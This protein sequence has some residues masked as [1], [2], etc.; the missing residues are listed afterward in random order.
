[1]LYVFG[2]ISMSITTWLYTIVAYDKSFENKPVLSYCLANLGGFIS[3]SSWMFLIRQLKDDK[4]ILII[5]IVWDVGI[6][7]MVILFPIFLFNVKLDLKTAIG[8]SIALLGIFI[9]KI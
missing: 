3:I 8:C 6:T 2:L 7:L 9:A 1:M 4:H 5:N